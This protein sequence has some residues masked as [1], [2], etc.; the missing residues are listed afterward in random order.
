MGDREEF[1][2]KAHE[3]I[4]TFCGRIVQAS[5]IYETEAWGMRDQHPFLNQALVLETGL[6]P[7]QLLTHILE[8][9]RSLGRVRELKY[10]PRTIDIDILFFDDCIIQSPHLVIP[11]PEIQNR[12][13]ALQCVAEI[14]PDYVHPVLKKT[15]EK[16][17]LECADPLQAVVFRR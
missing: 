2:D 6:N 10:G 3:K 17:L 7:E 16:L 15:V 11:H 4:N 14:M 13:F 9:E 8:I 12:L 5:S 1:L